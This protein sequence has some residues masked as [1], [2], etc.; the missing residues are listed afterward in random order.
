[1]IPTSGT[2]GGDGGT[3]T[4]EEDLDTDTSTDDDSHDSTSDGSTS[5]AEFRQ[6]EADSGGHDESYAGAIDTDDNDAD[7][8]VDEGDEVA[9]IA[10]DSSE[11]VEDVVDTFEDTQPDPAA[12]DVAPDQA[13]DYENTGGDQGIEDRLDQL[14]E[15]LPGD[16]DG[17]QVAVGALAVAAVGFAAG[18][19]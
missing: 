4:V 6:A 18:G 2:L 12:D 10:E 16:L 9:D 13:V 5:Y 14:A 19:S 15:R 7:A 17:T 1:M 11:S 3:V 8:V